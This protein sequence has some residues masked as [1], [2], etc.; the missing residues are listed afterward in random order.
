MQHDVM[1]EALRYIA[2]DLTQA[3]R[4]AIVVAMVRDPKNER[5]EITG[6]EHTIRA[7]KTG[8]APLVDQEDMYRFLTPLG[9]AVARHIN[10]T[11]DYDIP[12]AEDLVPV[13]REFT[14][15]LEGE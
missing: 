11:G 5:P 7:L 8:K 3:Q 13:A 9:I 12:A 6:S 14:I 15:D 10:E 4:R 2:G 1:E